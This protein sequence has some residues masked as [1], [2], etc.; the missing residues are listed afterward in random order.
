VFSLNY[1]LKALGFRFLRQPSRPNA[2]RPVAK[3]GRVAGRGVTVPVSLSRLAGSS[4]TNR[5][6]NIPPMFI[7]AMLL[8]D[9]AV[10]WVVIVGPQ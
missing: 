10:S 2:P 7:G 4:V 5:S 8:N 9:N 6:K 1:A 3:S